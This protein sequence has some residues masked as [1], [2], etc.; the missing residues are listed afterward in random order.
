MRLSQGAVLRLAML[1][2]HYRQPL[3][4]SPKRIEE[5]ETI[6][7]RWLKVCVPCDKEASIEFVVTLSNDLNTLD[8]I[9]LMHRYRKENK[10]EEL[11]AAMKFLGFFGDE[12]YISEVKTLPEDQAQDF[13]PIYRS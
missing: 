5:A 13:N 11:F 7:T 3:D 10:G 1:M 4:F 12:C 8:A 6:L 9:A 2:T